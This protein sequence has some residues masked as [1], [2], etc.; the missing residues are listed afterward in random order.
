MAMTC[1]PDVADILLE[2]LSQ[3]ILQARARG[4][5]GDAAAAARE[6]DH[7]HNL[8]GL[9]AHFTPEQLDYYWTIER[10]SYLAGI[11]PDQAAPFRPLWDRL[12]T[13]MG[14]DGRGS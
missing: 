6:A 11:A 3:G 10:P 12:R 1:P 13:A 4:W 8:P 2:I 7:V 9:I 5:S 14:Q